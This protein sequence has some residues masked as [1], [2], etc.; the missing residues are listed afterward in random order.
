MVPLC[1]AWLQVLAHVA[2]VQPSTAV[3]SG[4][5]QRIAQLSAPLV[6][7]ALEGLVHLIHVICIIRENLLAAGVVFVLR[8]SWLRIVR[9]CL[10]HVLL[11]RWPLLERRRALLR[12][13][14]DQTLIIG[15]AV[16][17]VSTLIINME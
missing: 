14:Y 7:H 5:A 9:I 8:H 1:P 11:H 16:H 4:M 15:T 12:V 17:H 6:V 13:G 3:V 10:E 2:I